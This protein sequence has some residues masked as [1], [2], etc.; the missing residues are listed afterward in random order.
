MA[1]R[2]PLRRFGE[3][4]PSVCSGLQREGFEDGS[5]ERYRGYSSRSALRLKRAECCEGEA[6]TGGLSFMRINVSLPRF[7]E[8]NLDRGW[9]LDRAAEGRTTTS[10]NPRFA[11]PNA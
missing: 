6:P 10:P 3:R 1:S 9:T 7:R 5:L 11:D 8:C 4:G 2:S